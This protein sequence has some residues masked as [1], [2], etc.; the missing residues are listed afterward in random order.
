MNFHVVNTMITIVS[1]TFISVL[2][3][4]ENSPCTKGRFHFKIFVKGLADCNGIFRRKI[5]ESKNGGKLS[6]ESFCV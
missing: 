3:A 1:V 5:D 4:M 2:T 6:N